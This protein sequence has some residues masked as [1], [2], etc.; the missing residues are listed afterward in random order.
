MTHAPQ[1][2]DEGEPHFFEILRARMASKHRHASDILDRLNAVYV[3]SP[4]DTVLR[5]RFDRFLSY[6]TAKQR[7][8]RQGKGNAL[9]VTG[10]SGAGKTDMVEQLLEHHPVMQSV[11][12]RSRMVRPWLR[13]AL[14]GPATLRVL[15][16]DILNAIQ[17]RIK[18][19]AR[20]AEVWRILPEQLAEAKV[21]LVHID[22]T[23]HLMSKGA[24]TETV[25]SAIKG[26]MN[27]SAWPVSFVLS[28]KPK[29]NELIIHDDQAQ[30]R[31]FSLALPALDSE[32]DRDLIE[33][34]IR[35]HCTAVDIA[36]EGLLK[37]DV[38]ARLAHAANFQFGRI[39]EVLIL[40][41][42]I[43]V[44]RGDKE[45]Q[46]SHFARAY[47]DHSDT[48]GNDEM[49]PFESDTWQHLAPGYFVTSKNESDA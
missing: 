42:H 14:Q 32:D 13:V 8:G 36:C 29:L 34:I 31:S 11:P 25:A 9:F 27:Y 4:R 45:L 18:A 17:Y 39:C 23:Q 19:T 35:E 49:N 1:S 21:F 22:E 46:R 7:N 44:L 6:T 41:I 16:T 33:R 5:N 24:D 38:P 10:E 15:G 20:E 26:L 28:G 43:A 37:S 3:E 12:Y 40:G 30:R 47:R 48:N 2:N